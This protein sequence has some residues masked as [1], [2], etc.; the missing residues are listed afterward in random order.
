[1]TKQELIEELNK[2]VSDAILK[3]NSNAKRA[4]N[5]AIKLAKQLDEPIKP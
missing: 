2:Y 1:M 4:F 5:T 3:K